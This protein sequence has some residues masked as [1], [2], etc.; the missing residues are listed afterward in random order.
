MPSQGWEGRDRQILGIRGAF[1]AA[2]LVCLT[3][4][5]PGRDPVTKWGGGDLRNERRLPAM[6]IF[7]SDFFSA[8]QTHL[9]SCL[10]NICCMCPSELLTITLKHAPSLCWTPLS[11]AS[12]T[13]LAILNHSLSFFLSLL[14]HFCILSVTLLVLPLTY[15]PKLNYFSSSL[16][17]SLPKSPLCLTCNFPVVSSYIDLTSQPLR[18][19]LSEV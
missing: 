10:T 6:F 1:R 13:P 16:P 3:S 2:S 14:P 4:S 7:Q 5:E 12:S 15:K 8:F 19:T 17:P 11:M 9:P 18:P